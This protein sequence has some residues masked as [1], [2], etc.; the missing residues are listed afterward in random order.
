MTD[1]PPIA[2]LPDP[3]PANPVEVP[4]QAPVEAPQPAP[5]VIDPSI[6]IPTGP[7]PTPTNPGTPGGPLSPGPA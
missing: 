1:L 2:A 7:S 4:S 6:G 3:E 5:D